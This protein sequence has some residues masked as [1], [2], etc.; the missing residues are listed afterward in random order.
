MERVPSPKRPRPPTSPPPEKKRRV[1]DENNVKDNTLRIVTE[2]LREENRQLVQDREGL[3]QDKKTLTTRL[4]Q[5]QRS[6]RD[7]EDDVARVYRQKQKEMDAQRR[8]FEQQLKERVEVRESKDIRCTVPYSKQTT[9]EIDKFLQSCELWYKKLETTSEELKN[10]MEKVETQEVQTAVRDLVT[11][12]EMKT[13][14]SELEA[15][16]QSLMWTSWSFEDAVTCLK[17]NCRDREETEVFE[18]MEKQL[19]NDR[20]VE[21]E[22]QLA[23][24]RT[25]E[26]EKE[27][28]LSSLRADH[29]ERM[30][31]S[32][33]VSNEESETLV[34]E[35]KTVEE[36]LKKMTDEMD[37]V[38]QECVSLKQ[39]NEKLVEEIQQLRDI[40]DKSKLEAS[41]QN[42]EIKKLQEQLHA[43]KAREAKMAAALKSTAKEMEKSK[44]R[45][46]ELKILYAK[47]SSTMDSVSEKTMRLEEL[48][49][50]M[51]VAQ[52]N[53]SD[54]QTQNKELEKQVAQLHQEMLDL[55]ATH[56]REKDDMCEELTSVQKQCGELRELQSQQ[57]KLAATMEDEV[58]ELKIQNEALRQQQVKQEH[59]SVGQPSNEDSAS[60]LVTQVAEKEATQMFM[61]RYYNAAEDKC[62]RLLEKVRE[63]ESQKT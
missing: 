41:Q 35:K 19:M 20:V 21:L 22:T 39:R 31:L 54:A 47:F 14:K 45:K 37:G 59:Q 25:V 2:M 12:V 40:Q 10:Q 6:L 9:V 32:H 15:K 50:K 55:A 13:L 11:T 5:A 7:L 23:Q 60:L 34:A 63:L 29:E 30:S 46:E 43:S 18:A 53:A 51:K 1:S 4:E 3:E 26:R 16:Q 36:E 57:Q 17:K 48:E 49:D 38:K 52:S 62:N 33:V 28:E 42:E 58:T 8:A 61:Q 24:K 27:M 56:L 44:Q